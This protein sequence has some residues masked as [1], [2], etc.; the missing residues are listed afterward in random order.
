MVIDEMVKRAGSVTLSDGCI[1]HRNQVIK[2]DLNL[3][4]VR[5]MMNI[6][7]RLGM[8]F[9]ENEEEIESRVCVMEERD[10]RQGQHP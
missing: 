1:E 10:E 3:Q 6:G 8:Q 7:R 9:Q 2:R 5:K 4:E